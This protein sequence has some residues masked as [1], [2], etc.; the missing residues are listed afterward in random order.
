MQKYN[1]IAN[2]HKIE[3][4]SAY[5]KWIDSHTPEQIRLANNARHSLN[6]KEGRKGNRKLS[7]LEDP[8][9]PKRAPPVWAFFCKERWSSGDFKGITAPEGSKRIW[10]EW[11]ELSPS[12]R[13]V[14]VYCSLKKSSKLTQSSRMKISE[15]LP[16]S[17]MSRNIRQF[18]VAI[19]SSSIG[20]ER[21]PLDRFCKI[22]RAHV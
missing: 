15:R 16:C 11:K 17:G 10:Q 14:C 7:L 4:E 13:K 18:S 1:H 20:S 22:G 21:Q 2:Q 9:I 3:N 12:Q 5:K 8:R 6:K 19:Q